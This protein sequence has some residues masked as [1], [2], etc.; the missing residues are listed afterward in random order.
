MNFFAVKLKNNIGSNEINKTF[1]KVLGKNHVI[2]G[3]KLAFF[4]YID[5]WSAKPN[6]LIAPV[7]GNSGDCYSLVA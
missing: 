7:P 4:K 3:K 5:D 6:N 2:I 1:Q